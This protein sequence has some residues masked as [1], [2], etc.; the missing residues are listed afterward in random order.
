M[1]QAIKYSDGNLAVLDQLQLPHVEQY[2]TIRTTEEAWHAIR[3]MRVR[4]APAI[5]IVAA[6][7]LASEL[8]AL[9]AD[10]LLPTSTEEVKNLIVAKLHY[11]VTSRPTAVNLSDISRK[12]EDLVVGHS[13]SS[14]CSGYSTAAA[15]IRAAEGTLVTD[16]DDNKRIG[17]NGAKWIMSNALGEGMSEAAVLT[18]CNTGYVVQGRSIMR[19]TNSGSLGP[20]RLRGM[21]RL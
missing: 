14:G 16:V 2:V 5:A 10:N 20:L 4:G 15:F 11:L 6:L 18:H 13:K 17:E 8:S 1:L 12:L 3:E 7:G 19:H 9:I 21:A